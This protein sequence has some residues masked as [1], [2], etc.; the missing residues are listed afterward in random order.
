MLHCCVQVMA[1]TGIAVVNVTDSLS[2]ERK[3]ARLTDSERTS[4]SYPSL[5]HHKPCSHCPS[6]S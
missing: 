5:V 2:T 6:P 1:G 4:F 3:A